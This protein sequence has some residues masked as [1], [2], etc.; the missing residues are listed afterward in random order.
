MRRPSEAAHASAV[1]IAVPSPAARIR[2][3]I[4]VA[5]V[6]SSNGRTTR[7][8]P[9]KS[10][11]LKSS[12]RL[13]PTMKTHCNSRSSFDS[14]APR[15]HVRTT[16]VVRG[17]HYLRGVAGAHLAHMA[18][19]QIQISVG[20]QSPDAHNTGAEDRVPRRA[21]EKYRLA[22]AGWADYEGISLMIHRVDD[23]PHLRNTENIEVCRDVGRS[24]AN[25]LVKLS[26]AEFARVEIVRW[27][28][29]ARC[30]GGVQAG[31]IDHRLDL[32]DS[33]SHV[34]WPMRDGRVSG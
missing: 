29:D 11:G 33:C 19:E 32:G 4:K 18:D 25:T 16:Q 30:H 3:A 34:A 28:A 20:S 10:E 27:R 22:R 31:H 23:V 13:A 8:L 15:R 21:P 9:R 17:D 7:A 26:R 5:V 12:S 6:R 14:P 24:T 1:S 2:S